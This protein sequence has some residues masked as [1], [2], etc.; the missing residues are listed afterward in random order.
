MSSLKEVLSLSPKECSLKEKGHWRGTT[1]GI[2][3][4]RS[5]QEKRLCLTPGAV[6]ILCSYGHK[7]LFEKGAGE[8]ISFSDE[9]YASAGAEVVDTTE[10]VYK[11]S[12]VAKVA[13]P[14]EEEVGWMNS[15][16][17]LVSALQLTHQKRSFFSALVGKKLSAIG[18]ELLKDENGEFPII[19]SMSEIA[20]GMV[21][22][23]AAEYLS[24]TSGGPGICVG[25]L[26][27]VAPTHVVILG[28]G[29]VAEYTARAALGLGARVD[30]INRT[31]S[32]L[33]R[34][35]YLVGHQ[36]NTHV[37]SQEVLEGLL[38]RADV[39]VAAIRLPNAADSI[40]VTEDMVRGMKKGAVIV[41]VSVDRNKC[42]ETS[43]LTSHEEPTF[44]KHGVVH[45]CVPNIASRVARTATSMLSNI[46]S[47]VIQEIARSGDMY[48]L[49]KE[50]KW[51]ASSVYGYQGHL[52]NMD[53]A[54]RF[55]M[56]YK[57]LSLLLF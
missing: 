11:A 39:F 46:L 18:F 32:S 29:T 54:K 30:V 28:S 13:P 5:L 10:E 45:Y 17:V 47:P 6:G 3:K 43:K 14:T 16:A 33:R 48:S 50:K 22:H 44:V 34:I 49:M 12:I 8:G 20:G 1:I 26:T 27:G 31:L 19:R 55:N 24:N 41:G 52:T 42:V 37:L 4:N 2:P 36:I 23:I 9:E 15:N 40:I 21:M 7:V 25:G 53:L 57:D 38:P 56:G 35:R 51:I